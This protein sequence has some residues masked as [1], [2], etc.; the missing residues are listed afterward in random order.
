MLNVIVGENAC[1]KT[2]ILSEMFLKYREDAV[3]NFVYDSRSKYVHLNSSRVNGLDE[4]V[5]ELEI[6]KDKIV[7][8]VW[9]SAISKTVLQS[10]TLELLSL[11]C[12]DRKY[13]FL[14]EPEWFIDNEQ[15]KPV[16]WFLNKSLEDCEIWITTHET[17]L[18]GIRNS[19]YYTV[20][21]MC[22]LVQIEE[23]N[24]YECIDEIRR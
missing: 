11:L 10:E 8:A 1:G 6:S 14:D 17:R 2:K 9:E 15:L 21:K 12:K 13:V 19:K 5:D 22:R 18:L 24:A 3:S 7:H 23:V 20:D 4:I 16:I